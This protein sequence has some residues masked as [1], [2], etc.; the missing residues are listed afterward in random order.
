MLE[1]PAADQLLKLLE[2]YV[3]NGCADHSQVPKILEGLASEHELPQAGIMA[4]CLVHVSQ[5]PAKLVSRA[6]AGYVGL[7]KQGESIPH[8]ATHLPYLGLLDPQ[9]SSL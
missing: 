4:R 1:R 6:I 5:P 2:I 9:G 8:M 7:L 3:N